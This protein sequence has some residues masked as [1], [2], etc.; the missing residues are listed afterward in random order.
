MAI[1]T[2]PQ[3]DKD[4]RR[5]TELAGVRKDYGYDYTYQVPVGTK[6]Y[7]RDQPGATWFIKVLKGLTICRANTEAI[8][9]KTGWKTVNPLPQLSAKDLATTIQTQDL[10]I[11]FNYYMTD[12]G[13][14][15]GG[16]RPK[17]LEDYEA[18]FQK[19]QKPY[20]V[21]RFMD[22]K[23]F[24]HSYLAGPNANFFKAIKTVPSN[25]PIDNTIF[26]RT[27]EFASDDLQR[28]LNAGRVF[29]AD[30]KELNTMSPGRHPLQQK[31]IYQP[32]VAFAQPEAGG[33]M[34][35]FAIQCGQSPSAFPIFGPSDSWA[36]QMAKGTA[37]AAH[38]MYHE[39][40]THLGLTHLLIEP[41]VIATRR[42]LHSRHPIYGLLSPHFEGTMNINSLAVSR[43]IQ[44][45]Q[46][47]DRL[48][49]SNQDS[50]HA[51]V[52][53]TRLDYSFS[54]NYLPV[55]LQ[56]NGV[57]STKALPTYHYRDDALPIWNAIHS[58][59]TAYVDCYYQGDATVKA[60]KELQAWA[61]EIS[62]PNGGRVKDFAANG[63]VNSKEQLIDTCTMIIFT[64]GPQHA[65]VN[66]PQLS[67]MTFL[68]G[69]PLSGYRP[70]PENRNMT[71]QDYLNF[72]PPLD[73]AITQWQM[74]QFLGSTYHTA[75]GKYDLG[76]FV[77]PRIVAANLKFLANLARIEGD[78]KKRNL[79]RTPYEHLLPSRIPQSTNI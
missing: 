72:L 2:I 32:I 22:D 71:K 15:Q 37:W 16:G 31:H 13:A 20:T 42:Q 66:F 76:Y 58:W 67:D 59:V 52:A 6:L 57:D 30:Y 8:L 26:R 24:A 44:D 55:R 49:G 74:L 68:P 34:M 61:A 12:L 14:I 9:D 33:T 39:M 11:L 17:S 69:A 78:I 77:D 48:V 7:S 70:A 35:P 23:Y 60:D 1:F 56:R 29:I 19:V 41:L 38:Y 18:V 63:G 64:A 5:S 25:F 27:K 36:W 45:G 10:S 40:L 79:S 4:P 65:A 54:D 62:S 21:A 50:N 46:A 53:T 3:S 28:A 51:I 73:V 47:V 75:L 43:L